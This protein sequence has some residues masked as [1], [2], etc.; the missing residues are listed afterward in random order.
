MR[1]VEKHGKQDLGRAF[2]FRRTGKSLF[3]VRQK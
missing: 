3:V 2:Y 1:R